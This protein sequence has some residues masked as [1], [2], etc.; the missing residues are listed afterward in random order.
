[1]PKRFFLT[2]RHFPPQSLPEFRLTVE[3]SQRFSRLNLRDACFVETIKIAKMFS[4]TS[5]ISVEIT[6]RRHKTK[7][8]E[9]PKA[10]GAF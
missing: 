1:M 2:T 5:V 9:K 4:V 10:E 8:P 7:E 6:A 3:T